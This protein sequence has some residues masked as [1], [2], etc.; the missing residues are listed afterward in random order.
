MDLGVEKIR[1]KILWHL[2][3][4]SL[5][6]CLSILIPSA[7]CRSI[8]LIQKRRWTVVFFRDTRLKKELWSKN[9]KTWRKRRYCSIA[10]QIDDLSPNIHRSRPKGTKKTRFKRC[11]E[12]GCGVRKWRFIRFQQISLRFWTGIFRDRRSIWWVWTMT[13]VARRVVNNVSF[14]LR[15]NYEIHF[16]WQAQYLVS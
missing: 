15:I 4:F 7:F 5:C 12:Q 16:S 10:C 3:A 6:I 1:L 13:H 11:K 9:S 2:C 14:V 8:T